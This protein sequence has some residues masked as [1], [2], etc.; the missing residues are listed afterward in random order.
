MFTVHSTYGERRIQV[1]W[2]NGALSGDADAVAFAQELARDLE[3]QTVGP[4][5][6]PYT[7]HNHLQEPLSALIIISDAVAMLS[8]DGDSDTTVTG[9]VPERPAIPAGA[10]G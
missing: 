9:D 7:E 2:N 5:E 3:G 6:G 4:W 8:G 1:S 10:I